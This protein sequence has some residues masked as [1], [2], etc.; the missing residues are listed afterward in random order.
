MVKKSHCIKG[1][2]IVSSPF[3]NIIKTHINLIKSI[4]KREEEDTF[5]FTQEVNSVTSNLLHKIFNSMVQMSYTGFTDKA[6]CG[7]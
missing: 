6:L 7:I 1:N 2:K 3:K 5:M 4:Y